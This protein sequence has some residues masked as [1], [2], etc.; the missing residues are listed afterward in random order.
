MKAVFI[1]TDKV[2]V[3]SLTVYMP[4]KSDHIII[5][6]NPDTV[7][8]PS[9]TGSTPNPKRCL[10]IPHAQRREKINSEK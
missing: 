6:S 10:V 3:N 9:A 8:E 1:R 5:R 4:V 7:R 2:L